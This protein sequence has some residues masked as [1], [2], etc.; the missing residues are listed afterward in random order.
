M[1]ALEYRSSLPRTIIPV[2]G[3]HL[4]LQERRGKDPRIPKED[5]GNHW[6]RKQYSGRK[7]VGF[8]PAD[9]YKFPMLSD[10]NRSE[11]IGKI[12]KISDRNTASEKKPWNYTETAVSR[13]RLFH[14]GS[15]EEPNY[16]R[17]IHCKKSLVFKGINF[18]R[19]IFLKCLYGLDRRKTKTLA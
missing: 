4:I 8:F 18:N 9:S 3:F 16:K 14:M 7:M 12:P 17:I 6:N 1:W 10:R 2:T 19:K 15:I 13:P 5:T 11:F